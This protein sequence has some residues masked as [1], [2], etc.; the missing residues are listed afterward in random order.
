MEREAAYR[1]DSANSGVNFRHLSRRRLLATAQD[2]L[3]PRPAAA[4]RDARPLRR[5]R[6][7][8]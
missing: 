8:F 3:I 4:G 2:C 1:L 6:L 7:R 5:F